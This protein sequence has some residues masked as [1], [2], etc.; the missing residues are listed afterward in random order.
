[1]H[2]P[3]HG[4]LSLDVPAPEAPIAPAAACVTSFVPGPTVDDDDDDFN[5]QDEDAYDE[6][7]YTNTPSGDDSDDEY[8]SQFTPPPRRRRIV[9]FCTSF[10]SWIWKMAPPNCEVVRLTID[11]DLTSAEGLAKVLAAVS[12][13]N[14]QVLLFG[15]LPCTGGSQWQNINWK[16]GPDQQ[17]KTQGHWDIFEVL[18]DN[19]VKVAAACS[20]NGGHSAIEWP[21]ACSY[22]SRPVVHSFLR[23][24]SLVDYDFDGCVFGLCSAVEA[25][26]GNPVRSFGGSHPTCPSSKIYAS[27]VRIPLLSTRRAQE[28]TRRRAKATQM[29]SLRLYIVASRCMFVAWARGDRDYAGRSR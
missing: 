5:D 22:W 24:Y 19:F 7:Q 17:D 2:N 1:M 13:P 15:A 6:E 23:V 16:R 14:V 27:N 11:D 20:Q 18:F 21:C 25:T 28:Q 9:D 29:P 3:W 12:D 26:L 4:R 10:D 8:A